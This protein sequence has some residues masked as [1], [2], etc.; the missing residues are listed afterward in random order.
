MIDHLSASQIQTYL[1]CSLK[2]KYAYIDELPKPFKPSG[3]AL[4]SSLHAS[5]EWLHKKWQNGEEPNLESVWDIFEGDWYAQSRDEILFKD[6]ETAEDILSEGKNLIGIYYK[7][8]PRNSIVHIEL[9]FRLP[10]M[11]DC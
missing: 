10:R 9:P 5:L 6:F 7:H 2:Y 11:R 1:S 3:L 8:A 4:G